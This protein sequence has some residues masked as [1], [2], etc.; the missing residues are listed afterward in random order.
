V[1]E[2]VKRYIYLKILLNTSEIVYRNNIGQ[3]IFLQLLRVYDCRLG[4]SVCPVAAYGTFITH[5]KV[6]NRSRLKVRFAVLILTTK[7]T[8]YLLLINL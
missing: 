8:L 6:C 5:K 4:R 2:N 3:F 7:I 1:E